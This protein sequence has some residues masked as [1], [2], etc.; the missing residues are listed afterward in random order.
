MHDDLDIS[1]T[2]LEVGMDI[3]EAIDINP[4]YFDVNKSDIRP[5]AALE[6]AKIVEVMKAYPNMII[7]LGS[8]T[9]CRATDEYNRKLSDKRGQVI[10]SVDQE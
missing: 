3:G 7:E 4:I 10:C 6:L 9:D 5:D 2:K 8:H 1:L